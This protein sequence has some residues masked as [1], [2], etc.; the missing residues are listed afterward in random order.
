MLGDH[1]Q[2]KKKLLPF[3]QGRASIEQN[4]NSINQELAVAIEKVSQST[5]S[6]VEKV[7]DGCTQMKENLTCLLDSTMLDSTTIMNDFKLGKPVVFKPT[8][9]DTL[10]SCITNS[11]QQQT[12][13]LTSLHEDLL[14]LYSTTSDRLTALSVDSTSVSSITESVADD[15]GVDCV[16]PTVKSVESESCFEEAV[17]D[18]K[19]SINWSELSL[20]L[21]NFYDQM[22]Q[23]EVSKVNIGGYSIGDE[24]AIAIAE[25]LKVN[26]SVTNINLWNNSIGDEGAIAIA[27]ALKVNSS[28]S[29]IYLWK[30]SIG[31]EGASALVDALKINSSVVRLNLGENS[32]GNVGAIAI[33][34]VIKVSTSV[35]TI[36]LG[37]NSIGNDGAVSIAE[38]L[39]VNSSISMVSLDENSIDNQTQR[40]LCR[41]CF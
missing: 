35:A 21:K 25:A 16:T 24:G 40:S 33:A 10:V 19:A 12:S 5:Q 23:N 39:K 31:D 14:S 17:E 1:D 37:Y 32:I 18:K 8:I 20:E 9:T 28:V 6:T 7:V 29:T 34:E 36:D 4:I 3:D 11:I 15:V 27:E 26:S 13:V 30:N 41:I 38:A 22:I 2:H